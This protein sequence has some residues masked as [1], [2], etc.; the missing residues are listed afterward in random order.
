MKMMP[1][2]AMC[3][4]DDGVVVPHR[5]LGAAVASAASVEARE[6]KIAARL[7]AGES[8]MWVLGL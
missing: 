4:D 3:A 1:G 6:R 2:D 5:D 7:V 8:T